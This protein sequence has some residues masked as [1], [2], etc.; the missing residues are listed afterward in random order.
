MVGIGV[1]GSR[2]VTPDDNTV[3]VLNLAVGFIGKLADSSALV[4]S[5][6]GGELR[7]RD[8]GSILRCDKSVGVGGVA[9]YS[10]SDGFLCDSID[11][12]A[13][14]LENFGIC[15]QE[16]GAFHARTSGSSTDE[17]GNVNILETD[18]GVS[19]CDDVLD[20][21]V[22]TISELHNESL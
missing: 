6:E 4:K 11:S 8:R 16:I 3:D 17:N 14:G 19:G 7:L 22:S 10:H 2:V 12:L 20:A 21:R 1:L 18:H 15:L 5:G 13:L 9:D